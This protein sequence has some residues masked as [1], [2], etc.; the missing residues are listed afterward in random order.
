MTEI[1]SLRFDHISDMSQLILTK[2]HK[3]EAIFPSI[4]HHVSLREV[5]KS[6]LEDFLEHYTGYGLFK[7]NKL[8]CFLLGFTN[9]AKLKGK[10]N[11]CY[12]PIWGQAFSNANLEHFLSL[13]QH[14]AKEWIKSSIFNHLITYLPTNTNLQEKLYSIGFGLIVIDGVKSME[15][16]P[17][18]KIKNR[19]N[20][21]SFQSEDY[22]EIIRIEAELRS[23]LSESPIFLFNSNEESPS[24]LIAFTA[25]NIKTIVIEDQGKIIAAMRGI[26]GMNNL[27]IFSHSDNIAIN[28]A[29]IDPEY[30]TL[31]LGACL[32]NEI[33]KWGAKKQATTCSVDFESANPLASRFWLSYFTPIAFNAIRKIDSRL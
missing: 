27:D 33:L 29:Y 23:Y 19:F 22:E 3:A 8:I 18:K 7:D 12:I 1:K 28:L 9:I 16:I 20:I 11:G 2:F 24:S 32:I 26:I 25:D 17:T 15:L 10:E 21:R 31:G 5:L 13:Y 30:R 14:S 6:K 4:F